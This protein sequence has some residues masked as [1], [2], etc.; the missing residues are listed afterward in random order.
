MS[1]L[2]ENISKLKAAIPHHVDIVVATKYATMTD[3]GII[4]EHFPTLTF[5]ENR[6]QQGEE[7]Q[8][9]YPDIKNPW[10][11]IGHLQ[12]NKV[13]KVIQ[14]YNLIHSVDSERLISE[15]DKESKKANQITNILLQVNPLQETTKFGFNETSIFSAI[16]NSSSLTNIRI[17]GLMSMAPFSSNTEEIKKTFKKTRNLYDKI[18]SNGLQ[19]EHLSM[20]MSNDYEIAISEGANMIRVGSFIFNDNN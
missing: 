8:T 13:K 10:H 14:Q 3:I 6:V 7:K 1:H 2:I 20:G 17:K 4:S 9:Q 15:I 12:R 18:I 19:L 16:D 11:F 5:G